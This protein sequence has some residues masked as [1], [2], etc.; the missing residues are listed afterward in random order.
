MRRSMFSLPVTFRA[1]CFFGYLALQA[2]LVISAQWRPDFVFGFQMFNESSTL[3]IRLFRKVRQRGRERLIPV[4]DGAWQAK[5]AR[6]ERRTFHW[7][8]RVRD[9][10]LGVLDRPVHA[11]YGLEAQLFRLRFAL[12][13]VAAHLADDRETVALVAVVE[14]LKNGRTVPEVRFEEALP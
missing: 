12:R 9:G 11:S 14:P 7:S 6:G 2:W 4:R 13:D 8:D 10:V 5:D 3:T 1:A